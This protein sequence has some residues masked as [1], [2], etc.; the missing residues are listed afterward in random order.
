MVSRRPSGH[1]GTYMPGSVVVLTGAIDRTTA[2]AADQM[3][4]EIA[5]G[6]APVA[7]IDISRVDEVNGALLG[8]LV[9][10]TRRVGWRNGR[11]IIVCTR[12]DLRS[13]LEIAGL[14]HLAEVRSSWPAIS[15]E[16]A[17]RPRPG[18]PVL[19]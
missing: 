12:D 14:D 4:R 18:T 19:P 1:D 2:R 7:V 3:I 16:E 6:P 15:A 13:G 10:A 8:V 5:L 17:A 11:T 9:R